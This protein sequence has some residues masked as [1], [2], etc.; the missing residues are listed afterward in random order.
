MIKCPCFNCICVPVCRH[1][2]F[3]NLYHSCSLLEDYYY[4]NKSPYP[5]VHRLEMSNALKPTRWSVDDSGYFIIQ[6]TEEIN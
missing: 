3:S 4:G 1:K 2:T 6:E 5:R